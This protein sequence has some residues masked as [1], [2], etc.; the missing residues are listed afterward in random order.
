MQEDVAGQRATGLGHRYS[1]CSQCG[2]TF[3]RRVTQAHLAGL[4][5]DAR[6]EFAE[7][8][9]DCE[10]LIRQGEAPAIPAGDV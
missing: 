6:S 10:R 5:E 7:M 2:R 8:C 1:T 3:L 4:L 9:G